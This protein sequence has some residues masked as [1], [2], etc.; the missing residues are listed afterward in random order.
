MVVIRVG[1]QLS[2]HRSE[3][4]NS[5][6]LPRKADGSDGSVGTSFALDA[7]KKAEFNGL[8]AEKMSFLLDI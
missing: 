3:M 2:G 6:R 4:V 8:Q 7:G 5:Y 1:G